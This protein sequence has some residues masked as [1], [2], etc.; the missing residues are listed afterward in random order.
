MCG[1]GE[2]FTFLNLFSS[3]VIGRQYFLFHRVSVKIKLETLKKKKKI[4]DSMG[5]VLHVFAV[6]AEWRY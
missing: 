4:R 5:I 6:K 2:R 1:L 3:P